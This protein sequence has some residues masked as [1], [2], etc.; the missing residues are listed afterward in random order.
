MYSVSGVLS[1]EISEDGPANLEGFL[2]EAVFAEA[3]ESSRPTSVPN[4]QSKGR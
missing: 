2:C 1:N 3:V 4:K